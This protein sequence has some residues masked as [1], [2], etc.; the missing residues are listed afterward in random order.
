MERITNTIYKMVI[1]CLENSLPLF[2]KANLKKYIELIDIT[3]LDIV[4]NYNKY[5]PFKVNLDK[6]KTRTVI[7]KIKLSRNGETFNNN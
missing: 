4:E 5:L 3:I 6:K 7:E 2:I 1:E